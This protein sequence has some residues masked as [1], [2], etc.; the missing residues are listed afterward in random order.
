MKKDDAIIEEA[1]SLLEGRVADDGSWNPSSQSDQKKG[2][3]M[4]LSHAESGNQVAQV[5]IGKCYLEGTGTPQSETE[6][7]LW[8]ER[9]ASSGFDEAHME[10]GQ[11]YLNQYEEHIDRTDKTLA[12]AYD[13]MKKAADLGN[14]Y[15]AS[16]L[17]QCTPEYHRECEREFAEI[18]AAAESGNPS[19]QKRIHFHYLSGYGVKRSDEKAAF[20]IAE[21]E[22]NKPAYIAELKTKADNGDQMAALE[23]HVLQTGSALG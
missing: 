23:L 20:W 13:G 11:Y 6:G 21:F 17:E 22:K 1:T 7:I 16:K 5:K 14:R 4:L 15:A 19:A 12:L 18:L 8:L 3:E 10:L 9:S 2:F